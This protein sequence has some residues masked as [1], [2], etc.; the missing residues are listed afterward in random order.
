MAFDNVQVPEHC[1]AIALE[2]GAVRLHCAV[3]L[4]GKLSG[5][6]A[7]AKPAP[8]LLHASI[9]GGG[10]GTTAPKVVLSLLFASKM[11]WGP[12]CH[13][14]RRHSPFLFSFSVR[15]FWAVAVLRHSA[16]G[17]SYTSR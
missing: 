15:C 5:G 4:L 12:R 2:V 17:A 1:R 14:E 11:A 6:F 3:H 7:A 16:V 8:R 13:A 10:R 9:A